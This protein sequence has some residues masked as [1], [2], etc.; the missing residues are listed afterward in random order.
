MGE[1][2]PFGRL[3]A[4]GL[5]Q[6]DDETT[7]DLVTAV[8]VVLRDLR[9]I[10]HLLTADAARERASEARRLLARALHYERA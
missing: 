9:D 5:A 7:V 8:D 4:N 1:V 10:E 2:I 6:E 3:G